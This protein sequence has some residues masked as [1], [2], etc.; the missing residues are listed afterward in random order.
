[1]ANFHAQR[2]S[3]YRQALALVFFAF[4]A[5]VNSITFVALEASYFV[6]GASIWMMIVGLLTLGGMGFFIYSQRINSQTAD[7]APT[8]HFLIMGI[9]FTLIWFTS[10]VSVAAIDASGY[11]A[12]S[13]VY[14]S[15]SPYLSSYSSYY[16]SYSSYFTLNWTGLCA[17]AALADTFGWLSFFGFIVF[18]LTIFGLGSK[19][20]SWGGISQSAQMGAVPGL[21]QPGPGPALTPY[22]GQGPQGAYPVQPQEAYSPQMTGHQPYSPQMNLQQP[23]SP[24]VPPQ[25]QPY[26][27]VPQQQ[28]PYSPVM[29]GQQPYP[30]QQIPPQQ[31]YDIQPQSHLYSESKPQSP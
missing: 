15:Y 16:S 19:A 31:P 2:F 24:Q 17:T 20:G 21:A 14:S 22:S 8:L 9:F 28:Q 7:Y 6:S 26:S 11:C 1:M 30:P 27:P 10:A 12:L 23:Y 25:Q 4:V 13:S 29:P 5:F 18:T 3:V